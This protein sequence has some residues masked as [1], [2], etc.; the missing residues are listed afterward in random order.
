MRAEFYREDHPDE[1][2][3]VAEWSGSSVRIDA[4]DPETRRLLNRVFRLSPVSAT[5]PTLADPA[6]SARA[7]VPPGDLHWFRRAALV[8]G[9]REGLRIR[10]VTEKPGGW[11]PAGAYRPLEA[12]E[13]V[14]EGG[15]PPPTTLG[16]SRA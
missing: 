6:A 1:P 2:V 13:A 7:Q 14:R 12:W 10:L 3:G 8:R 11:D 9:E 16:T 15:T 4:P 5:D